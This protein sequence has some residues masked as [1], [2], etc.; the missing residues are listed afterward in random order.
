MSIKD[1]NVNLT[2]TAQMLEDCADWLARYMIYDNFTNDELKA[3]GMPTVKVFTSKITTD[4][5]FT[6]LIENLIMRS[7]ND[8]GFFIDSY[9]YKDDCL[10]IIE[11]AYAKCK[12][13]EQKLEEAA[14]EKDMAGNLKKNIAWLRKQG[15]TVTKNKTNNCSGDEN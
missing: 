11:D 5:A 9:R 14:H 1:L 10:D 3:A 2:I 12:A 13:A 4:P 8:P 7:T 6:K 15:Y